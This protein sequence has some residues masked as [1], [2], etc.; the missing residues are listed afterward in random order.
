MEI[1]ESDDEADIVADFREKINTVSP[2]RL[3]ADLITDYAVQS[4]Q[5]KPYFWLALAKAELDAGKLNKAVKEAALQAIDNGSD[6]KEQKKL[7][8]EK[9]ALVARKNALAAFKHELQASRPTRNTKLAF[10][11]NAKTALEVV[12][13]FEKLAAEFDIEGVSF[14]RKDKTIAKMKAGKYLDEFDSLAW[15]EYV[16]PDEQ[17]M[18]VRILLLP[19]AWFC[20][21]KGTVPYASS[22]LGGS[23]VAAHSPKELFANLRALFGMCLRGDIVYAVSGADDDW[24]NTASELFLR[25]GNY[26]APIDRKWV[27]NSDNS[28]KYRKI[29]TF[30]NKIPNDLPKLSLEE[31]KHFIRYVPISQ[32][33]EESRVF[34]TIRDITP[35]DTSI[36]DL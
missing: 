32:T 25:E 27:S 1:G 21:F 9:A 24:Y 16:P 15:L 29:K 14:E 26:F 19:Q 30:H 10:V 28:I 6:I 31:M 22:N 8:A 20:V 18:T 4:T 36:V 2:E 7:G 11:D 17:G 35:F 3:E 5:D 23:Y 13:L 33:Y 12:S 34:K